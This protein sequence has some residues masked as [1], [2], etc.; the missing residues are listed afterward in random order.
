MM[1]WKMLIVL[2]TLDANGAPV[3]TTIHEVGFDTAE[4]C[5]QAEQQIA[6]N[7]NLDNLQASSVCME[8][9]Q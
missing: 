8:I 5:F 2:L 6:A 1:T 3:E 7:L 4:L 9:S